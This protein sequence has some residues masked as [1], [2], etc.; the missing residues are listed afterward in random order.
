MPPFIVYCGVT[1]LGI[2]LFCIVLEISLL[3]ALNI[4]WKRHIYEIKDMIKD[5]CK[6]D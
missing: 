4:F 5:A 2:I 1:A 3:S 6:K